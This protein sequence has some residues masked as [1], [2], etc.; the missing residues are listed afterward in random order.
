MW[1][2]LEIYG[3]PRKFVSIIQSM[4]DGSESCVRVGQ[5]H[6]DWFSV[7]TGVRQGDVLS[8]LL[9]NILL[10]F[11]LRKNDTIECGI[12]WTGGKRL[13]DLDY[14]DDIC[15]LASDIE[16]MQM[17]VDTIVMEGEKIG[18]KINTAKTEVMK[19]RT[20]DTR[21][22]SIGSSNLKEVNNFIYLGSRMSND[23]DIRAEINIRIGKSSCAFNYLKNVWKE[24][25]ISLATKLKLFNA[26][27]ISVLLY[28]C[29]SWKGLKES[30]ERVRRFESNCLR[31]ILKIR[32]YD[33]VSEEELRRRTGQQSVVEKIKL[34]RWKWYG[35]VLRMPEERITKQALNWRP[36]GRRR[37]GRPKDTW[38]RTLTREIN[39]KNLQ[40]D[41]VRRRAE[42]RAAWRSFVADLWTT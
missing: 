21:C 7:A 2:I 23:G 32:W 14:A 15:L 25:R 16:E 34:A 22:V 29:E 40:E 38:R 1:K 35:H 18:L 36:E 37:I 30:E 24:D 20:Q 19:I 10:D 33:H 39:L 12:E 3:I 6:T 28:G 41:D 9:F 5:D 11:I 42:D 27:V 4:Y 13:R 17:M 26:I 31:R 8:P